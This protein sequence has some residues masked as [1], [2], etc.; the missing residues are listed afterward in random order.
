[1]NEI[2]AW[3]AVSA[4]LVI[5]ALAMVPSGSL[6]SPP[7]SGSG[8]FVVD[9]ANIV[10]TDV[11]FAGAKTIVTETEPVV[12][13]GTIS[14][15]LV[16]VFVV[17]IQPDGSFTARGKGTFSGTVNGVAGGFEDSIKASGSLATSTLQGT[18]TITDGTGGLAD[19][20]GRA[21][22]TGIPATS[23]TYTVQFK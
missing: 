21:A 20:S 3:W 4:V 15:I 7:A 16:H 6:A 18:F 10:V 11:R 19:L 5:A 13:S 8:S 23:G 1:M 2:R 17:T 12:L 22:F 14:G 9:A